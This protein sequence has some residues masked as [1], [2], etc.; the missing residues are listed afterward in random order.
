ME[1]EKYLSNDVIQWDLA[2]GGK[3]AAIHELVTILCQVHHLPEPETILKTI[4]AREVERST[5]MSHGVAIPHARTDL[6]KNIFVALGRSK[7][8][9]EWG[10]MDGKVTHF[11]FLVVGPAKASE[12]YLRLLADIS[13]LMSRVLVSSALLESNSVTEAQKIIA[14]TKTRENRI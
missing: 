5:A 1:L 9:I 10:S 6:V 4:F 3:E 14:Q 11:I 2:S 12:E 7:T 8:G 13:R